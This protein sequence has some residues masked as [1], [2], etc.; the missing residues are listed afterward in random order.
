MRKKNKPLR[1]LL[2]RNA[3]QE[4]A[5]GAEQYALNLAIALKQAGQR[6]ILVTN[7]RKILDK[8]GA[9]GL[10]TIRGKAD[11]ERGWNRG[12]YL[13]Y[14]LTVIWYMWI[15][16]SRRIDAVHPQSRDD[17]VFASRAAFILGKP[18][19]WTDHADLKY[20]LDGVNHFNPRM[21]GWLIKA[22]KKAGAIICVSRAEQEAIKAVAPDLPELTIVHTGAFV[23]TDVKPVEKSNKLI[24]GT[25]ARLQVSKGIAELME[26]LAKLK[27]KD[28]DLWLLG[29][30]SGNLDKYQALAKKLGLAGRV[31]FWDYVD[32]PNDVVAAMDIFV[33]ASYM[34]AFSL[35]IVE[36]AM[37]GRPIIA[38][39]VGGTPE[40]IDQTCGILIEPRKPEQITK[41]LQELI[42]NPA[43]RNQLGTAAEVKVK[44]NFD[45]QKIVE[46]KIIPLYQRAMSKE[47]RAS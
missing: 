32:E 31:K 40:I 11:K 30:A 6:P 9:A 41:A 42:D 22:A 33:H 5:G 35:A 16:L 25:N 24:I 47:Q 1:V 12:Y 7:V 8:A 36:A 19:I 46:R 37:L 14:P 34:E 21:R 43:R 10:K 2:I 38:T 4:D 18:V 29:G 26:G 23:P 44:R 17:F 13:R 3:Y 39:N 20:A 28:A 15:I 27:R 45:F